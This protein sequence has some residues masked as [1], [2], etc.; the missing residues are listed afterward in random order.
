[1]CASPWISTLPAA[2]RAL[3]DQ[4]LVTHYQV[5][6]DSLAI[7]ALI[8]RYQ[9]TIRAIAQRFHHE[10]E[11]LR[12]LM[13]DLF[14]LLRD[15]LRDTHIDRSFRS[16]LCTLVRNRFID[17]YRRQQVRQDYRQLQ[18]QAPAAED[19]TV[20]HTLD[21]RS[22]RGQMARILSDREQRCLELHFLQDLSYEDIAE[23]EGWTFK[24]V[25]G[26]MY[27]GMKKLRQGLPAEYQYA[28]SGA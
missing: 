3:S 22:L 23:R 18:Q 12:D 1:M 9:D 19:A 21:F 6:G 20:E 24:Q 14:M 15:K 17:Q 2:Y 5:E 25:C 27:R 13:Q 8:D 4:E 16:W 10:A 26:C 28:I 11:Y 7:A